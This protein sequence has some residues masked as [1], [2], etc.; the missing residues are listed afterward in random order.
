[1]SGL[2]IGRALT[3]GATS[4]GGYADDLLRERLA[5]AQEDRSLAAQGF[6]RKSALPAPSVGKEATSLESYAGDD[7]LMQVVGRAP[8]GMGIVPQPRTG[9]SVMGIPVPSAQPAAPATPG[10]D[11]PHPE[12]LAD[13]LAAVSTPKEPTTRIGGEAYGYH[14]EMTPQGRALA[15]RQAL[16]D[17]EDQAAYTAFRGAGGTEP[18]EAA[19]GH[20][21]EINR[22][23]IGQA[24]RTAVDPAE[25]R[26]MW[27]ALPEAVRRQAPYIEG[28]DYKPLYD[29]FIRDEIGQQNRVDFRVM[30]PPQSGGGRESEKDENGLRPRTRDE[31]TQDAAAEVEM[32]V[33][34]NWSNRQTRGGAPIVSPDEMR[35]IIHRHPGAS[36]SQVT[37]HANA[38]LYH[39]TPYGGDAQ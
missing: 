38:L 2:G 3:A 17:R 26:R 10:V 18:Y 16:E 7:P 31:Q 23:R 21:S 19:R 37:A 39:L 36:V 20:W 33:R 12:D 34:Q 29:S 30:F 15:L 27:E 35:A 8:Q 25:S 22:Q 11:R 28:H 32:L 9:R 1:M 13:A 24:S 5:R 14:P 6:F 4:L